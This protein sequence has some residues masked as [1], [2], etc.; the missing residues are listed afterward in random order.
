MV[1]DGS[2]GCAFT[3]NVVEDG[4]RVGGIDIDMGMAIMALRFPSRVASPSLMM[5]LK[6]AAALGFE[7]GDQQ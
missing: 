3:H 6:Q 4:R 5:M 7:L 1:S 2:D